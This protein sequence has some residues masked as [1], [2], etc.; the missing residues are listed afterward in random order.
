[1]ATTKNVYEI[2][3]DI[4][5]RKSTCNDEGSAAFIVEG[6]L[7]QDIYHRRKRKLIKAALVFNHK[8]GPD[9]LTVFSLLEDD[10]LKSDYFVYR[11][12][13]YLVIEENKR[14]HKEIN[15]RKSKA[16]ECNVSFKY[17]D[18][19][20]LGY[21]KSAMRGS[22]NPDFEGRHLVVP[23]ETPLII[24]PTNKIID[25]RSEF[26]IEGKPFKVVEYDHIT[27]KGITYYYLERGII[28]QE[29]EVE[30]EEITDIIPEGETYTQEQNIPEPGIMSVDPEPEAELI[31]RA[32]VEYTF[33]TEMAFF[34]TTPAVEIVSRKKN[35]IRFKVPFGIE[36][37]VITTKES[38]SE[39]EKIYKVVM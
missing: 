25:I 3:R 35:E 24:L 23:D 13:N 15:F 19:I 11:H 31:L 14:N 16:V 33:A 5:R 17:E 8:E 2:F 1:M 38:G 18:K 4:Q 22:E 12:T 29:G 10:L 34:T 39:I 20:F 6:G 37:L 7:S 9:E 36:Q 26:I 30:E 27:N 32:M 21:F 28:R